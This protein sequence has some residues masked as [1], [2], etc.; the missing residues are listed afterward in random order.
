MEKLGKLLGCDIYIDTKDKEIIG[1]AT[2]TLEVA[3]SSGYYH[4]KTGEELDVE[5]RKNLIK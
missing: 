4:V 3:F 1:M 2:K 5:V